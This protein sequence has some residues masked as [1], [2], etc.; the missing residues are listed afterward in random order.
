MYNADQD[1][2][3]KSAAP[4]DPGE[5]MCADVS[6][7]LDSREQPE[8][9]QVAIGN[10]VCHPDHRARTQAGLILNIMFPSWFSVGGPPLAPEVLYIV[11]LVPGVAIW[12]WSADLRRRLRQ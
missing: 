12:M 10:E 8:G 11:L 6:L 5:R 7:W 1:A 3:F 4:L 9:G 2:D